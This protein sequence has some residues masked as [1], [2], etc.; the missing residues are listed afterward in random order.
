MNY[1]QEKLVLSIPLSD[2]L[3]DFTSRKR[4]TLRPLL[5]MTRLGLPIWLGAFCVT[6]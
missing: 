4:S 6:K 3:A 2:V 5:R 1:S